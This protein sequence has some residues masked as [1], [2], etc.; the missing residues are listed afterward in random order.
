MN[1]DNRQDVRT[2]LEKRLTLEEIRA[3]CFDIEVDFDNLDG[4]GKSG[5]VT[6]LLI[7]LENRNSLNKALSWISSK[8]PDIELSDSFQQ[9]AGD[10]PKKK[11]GK[12]NI[13]LGVSI[14]L[15]LVL[16]IFFVNQFRF[17]VI[18]KF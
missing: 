3:L 12:E 5:K 1:A 11:I 4:R 9:I 17:T 7:H 16:F 13:I 10:V 2:L 14:T 18:Y 15:F 6:S 8:R